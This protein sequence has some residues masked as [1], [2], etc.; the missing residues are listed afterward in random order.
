MEILII[1]AGLAGRIAAG[2]LSVLPDAKITVIE[3]EPAGTKT[4]HAI[5]RL[6]DPEVCRL[7][8]VTPKE[9]K[10]QKR[11]AEVINGSFED[12]YLITTDKAEILANNTYSRKLYDE[13]GYR[14]IGTLGDHTRWLAKIPIGIPAQSVMYSTRLISVRNGCVTIG[15]NGRN[16][17]EI[18]SLPYD[19]CV[20]TIPMPSLISALPEAT[21]LSPVLPEFKRKS[22]PITVV[23]R[24]VMV[25]SSVH[26]TLYVPSLV[27]ST[28]RV[29]LQEQEIIYESTNGPPD[30]S[31]QYMLA[32]QFGI[33]STELGEQEVFTQPMGKML[34]ID[35]D[36]RRMA[37]MTLSQS[38]NIFSFGRF[39]IWK[40]IRTDHLVKDIEVI[41]RMM[42][43][44]DKRRSYE[45][46]IDQLHPGC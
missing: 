7:L 18:S 6:R 31:E 30:D 11:V 16:P 32:N 1:G 14:S 44:E 26:Q 42:T 37:I 39:A 29:T 12:A 22:V 8:G 15:T 23:R 33:R 27:L 19:F 2:A 21:G 10:V 24:K 5:M 9:I 4:H 3:K 41:K 46:R 34:P 35:E 28:Y 40:P 38:Y 36:L 17:P 45:S 13:I 43:I 25:R 20:S